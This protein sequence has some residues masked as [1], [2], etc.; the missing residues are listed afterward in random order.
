[1]K[2]FFGCFAPSGLAY[3]I[4]DFI[5]GSLS[6]TCCIFWR[7]LLIGLLIGILIGAFF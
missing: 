3:R 1:M 7:G 2:E 4:Y 6:C 5:A